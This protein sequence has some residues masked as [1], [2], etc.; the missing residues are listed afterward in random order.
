MAVGVTSALGMGLMG[1]A[2]A[3]TKATVKLTV[4]G[5]SSTVTTDA[6]VVAGLLD[7]QNVNYD[8]NDI[9]RPGPGAAVADGMDVDVTTAVEVTVVN[10]DATYRRVVTAKT[11][12]GARNELNLPAAQRKASTSLSGVRYQGAR[13]YGPQGNRLGSKQRVREGSKAV[14]HDFRI[15]FPRDKVRVKHHTVKDRSK[16]VRSGSKRVYKE[17]RNGRKRVVYRKKFV[18]QKLVSRTVAKSRW[19]KKPHRKVVRIGTGPNWRGLARCESGGNPNA[20]NP[21]GYYGLY[22]FSISTWHAVGGK[23]NP[24]D[25]GYWEQTKRAW[26]LFKHSGRSPWP[27]CGRFL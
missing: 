18:D 1:T 15:T 14:V 13:F 3:G 17:G 19:L 26:K 9:L 5:D 16:L 11:V 8:S 23:G 21:A 24:T 4:D 2:T 20:V 7:E 27:Y 6:P 12:N 10:D 25:Y 22:Q